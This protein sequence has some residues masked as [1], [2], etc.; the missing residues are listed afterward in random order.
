L[1]QILR[2]APLLGLWLGGLVACSSAGGVDASGVGG[3]ATQGGTSG[4]GGEGGEAGEA[5]EGGEGGE[6][7][8]GGTSG[9]GGTGGAGGGVI[10]GG[11]GGSSGSGG[12][13]SCAAVAQQADAQIL[14]AD[15]IWVVDTSGSMSE[16]MGFVQQNMNNFAQGILSVGIDVRV[17]LLAEHFECPPIFGC[18]NP[19]IPPDGICLPPPLGSG[20][21]PLDQNLPTYWHPNVTIGSTDG[22]EKIISSY[23]EW[24]GALRP[25][26]VKFVVVVTDDDARA[27][28]YAPENFPDGEK[29]SAAKFIQDF[30][31][32][33]PG[34][35]TGFKMSGIYC[36]T[37]CPAA[38]SIGKVW[39]EVV[40]QTSGVKGDLCKQQFQP[41]FN[42]LAKGVQK[43]ATL[44]CSWQIPPPPDGQTFDPKLVN[45]KYTSGG[46]GEEDIFFAASPADCDPGKGGWYY[47]K[48][49]DPKAV[50]VCPATCG[51]IQADT[52]G[53]IDILFGCATKPIEI[54]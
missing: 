47:D 46:G 22:L 13:P 36:F 50:Q 48:P 7:G 53:K 54:N 23:P 3:A 24:K 18:N 43:A 41:I 6:S 25:N 1:K 52:K 32:L 31:A 16:E 29:G 45:V 19:L 17:V 42:D 20:K 40:N 35:L 30:T 38:A 33:D 39:D 49:A 11:S 28:V 9:A 44:D 2:G 34:I 37:D 14:P 4:E 8:T 51:K 5:G 21:C 27:G 15:I 12:A 10:T 26:S